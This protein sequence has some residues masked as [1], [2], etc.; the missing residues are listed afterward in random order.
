[1]QGL[2]ELDLTA[3]R[4]Q[5]L[6]LEVKADQPCPGSVGNTHAYGIA[7]QGRPETR[8][9][10]KGNMVGVNLP[11]R[12]VSKPLVGQCALRPPAIEKTDLALFR[13]EISGGCLDDTAIYIEGQHRGLSM[14][15]Q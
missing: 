1:M 11:T 5:G 6:A 10:D 2:A 12:I 8:L 14:L 15:L 4:L 9:Y 3:I 7:G 13:S